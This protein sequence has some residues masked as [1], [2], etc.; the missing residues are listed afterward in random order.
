[1]EEPNPKPNN[2]KFDR[3]GMVNLAF[4]MGFVIALPLVA[5]G[6]LGKYLDGRLGTEPWLTIAGILIAII[7]TTIWLTRK[8]KGYI[9]R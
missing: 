1:M 2:P 4:D 3:W 6:L 7:S 9:K 5:F 8:L